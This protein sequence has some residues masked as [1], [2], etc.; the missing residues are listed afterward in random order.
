M[1]EVLISGFVLDKIDEL[2]SYLIDELK[3]SEEAVLR[4]SARMRKFIH[5]LGV[6]VDFP[7]CRFK[8]WR[9]FGYRC[10]VFEKD[11]IF[12]CEIFTDGIIVRDMSHS[13]LLYE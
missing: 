4:R 5:S 1:R 3:L 6:S 12:A 11:W 9:M 8:M 7:I 10:I 2:E 13:S